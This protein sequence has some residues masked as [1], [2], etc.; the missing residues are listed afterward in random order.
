MVLSFLTGDDAEV[1]LPN[2]SQ[3]TQYEKGLEAGKQL[4]KMHGLQ[5]PREYANWYEQKWS[6]HLSYYEASNH[7]DT[8]LKMQKLYMISSKI[9]LNL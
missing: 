7:A 4:K 3:K 9:M 5:A 2:C 1:A 6:K 8:P